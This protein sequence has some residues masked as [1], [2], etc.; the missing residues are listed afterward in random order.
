[1]DERKERE[2]IRKRGVTEG[3]KMEDKTE[4]NT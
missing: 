1:M 3:G 4:G 2:K